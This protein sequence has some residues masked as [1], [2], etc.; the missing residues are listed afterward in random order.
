MSTLSFDSDE[1][2]L[3]SYCCVNSKSG[4]TGFNMS[5]LLENI[6]GYNGQTT[7]QGGVAFSGPFFYSHGFNSPAQNMLQQ[8]L[9]RRNYLAFRVFQRD[10]IK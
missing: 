5:W 3:G 2:F 10:L 7:E 9:N 6:S 8:K 4:W 1:A